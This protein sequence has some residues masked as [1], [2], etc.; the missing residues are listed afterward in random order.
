V[1]TPTRTMV[2]W[3]PDW[4]VTAAS[5]DL[6]LDDSLPIALIDKGLV[7]ACSAAVTGQSGLHSTMVR[8]GVLTPSPPVARAAGGR[9]RRDSQH[10]DLQH[11]AG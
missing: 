10:R 1:S 11:R 4:P 5:R 8:V 6:G 3:S 7:L 9:V 2:L